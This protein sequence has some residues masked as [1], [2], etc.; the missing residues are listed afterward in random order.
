MA[1]SR[2][3]LGKGYGLRVLSSREVRPAAMRLR[4]T[5]LFRVRSGREDRESAHRCAGTIVNRCSGGVNGFSRAITGS[6]LKT[7]WVFLGG[8]NPLLCPPAPCEMRGEDCGE[9][10]VRPPADPSHLRKSGENRSRRP[11]ISLA[12]RL[13]CGREFRCPEAHNQV[14]LTTPDQPTFRHFLPPLFSPLTARSRT[15]SRALRRPPSSGL[16]RANSTPR[17]PTPCAPRPRRWP[18]PELRKA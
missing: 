13:P 1:R 5:R 9:P 11:G 4:E 15:R 8:G 18:P 16:L 3:R 14:P 17:R 2:R 6:F 7:Y 10:V 12:V